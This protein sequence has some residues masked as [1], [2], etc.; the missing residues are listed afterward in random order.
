MGFDT[1]S[2]GMNHVQRKIQCPTGCE[3]IN[4]QAQLGARLLCS[5]QHAGRLIINGAIKPAKTGP[6]QKFYRTTDLNNLRNSA[7]ETIKEKCSR[8]TEPERLALA[9]GLPARS[10]PPTS[11]QG[12]TRTLFKGSC[13][14]MMLRGD[15][16]FLSENTKH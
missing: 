4:S 10:T 16:L 3:E 6:F 8:L 15:K 11:T 2:S 7:V 5:G 12:S 13:H 1:A 14:R 9:A